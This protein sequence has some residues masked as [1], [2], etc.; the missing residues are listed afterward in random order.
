MFYKGTIILPAGGSSRAVPS[1]CARN[2]RF[3]AP[4]IAC[5]KALFWIC[6]TATK[7]YLVVREPPHH[8]PVERR[9][10]RDN[11]LGYIHFTPLDVIMVHLYG[12]STRMQ[13]E[14]AD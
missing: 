13:Q 10:S 14:P 7:C 1:G 3:S 4:G 9:L 5:L 8:L 12:A 6:A 11:R 2:G